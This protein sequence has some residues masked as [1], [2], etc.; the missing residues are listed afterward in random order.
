MNKF[1]IKPYFFILFF[2]DI[3]TVSTDTI[4]LFGTLGYSLAFTLMP[5]L[6]DHFNKSSNN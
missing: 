6:T 4:I 2:F 3:K 1:T 5:A